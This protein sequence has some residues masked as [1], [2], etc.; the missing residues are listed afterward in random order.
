MSQKSQKSLGLLLQ[1]ARDALSECVQE[2]KSALELVDAAEE[3]E[4]IS[5]VAS[6]DLERVLSQ[7]QANHRKLDTWTS[8]L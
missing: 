5:M 4:G 7:C 3:D 8:R 2:L 6:S 1:S